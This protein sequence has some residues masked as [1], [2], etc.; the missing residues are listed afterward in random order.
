MA[1]DDWVTSFE[2]LADALRCTD[3]QKVDY[4]GMKP[5]G[6]AKYW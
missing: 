6:E 2:D 4:A 5:I 3:E 1:T